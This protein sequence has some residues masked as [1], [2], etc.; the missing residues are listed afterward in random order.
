MRSFIKVIS[1]LALSLIV[2]CTSFAATRR[3][4]AGHTEQEAQP[5]Q[6]TQAPRQTGIINILILGVD[7]DQTRTDT[8]MA[9]SCNLDENHVRILSVPR[10][11]RVYFG[12]DYHKINAAYGR[13]GVEQTKEAVTALTGIPFNNYMVFTTDAFRDVID[14]LGGVWFDVPRDMNYRDPEQNLTINL[15]KGYQMLDGNK[16]EQLV[17]F[18]RY[19]E[20][21]IARVHMQQKF[22]AA[23]AEQ[24]LNKSIITSLPRLYGACSKNITTDITLADIMRHIPNVSDLSAENVSIYDLPGDFNDT[25]Y[26]V[27]YWICDKT[28]TKELV[29]AEFGY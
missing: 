22:F 26:G 14:A 11:T 2:V 23:L 28:K 21:D 10:D 8:I 20:G 5:V 17:R 7:K 18:R 16:A 4:S 9:V 27:S 15:K 1:A 6:E 12:G 19:P 13:G 3:M 25:D 24:K 29:R